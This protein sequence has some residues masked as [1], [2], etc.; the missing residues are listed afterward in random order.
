M[1]QKLYVLKV[2]STLTL[3]DY[4]IFDDKDLFDLAI[5]RRKTFT[6]EMAKNAQDKENLRNGH[7]QSLDQI[8]EFLNDPEYGLVNGTLMVFIGFVQAFDDFRDYTMW[9]RD[10]SE[11]SI[12]E[13]VFE[14][15]SGL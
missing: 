5:G 13:D 3:I 11:N 14:A 4:F 8:K 15:R 7:S 9:L 12:V 1:K 10:N 2:N 6:E